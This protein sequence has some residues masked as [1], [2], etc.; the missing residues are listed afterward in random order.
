MTF[1]WLI[2]LSFETNC[3]HLFNID[4][5]HLLYEVINVDMLTA[6]QISMNAPLINQLINCFVF[7][8]GC[9]AVFGADGDGVLGHG[10]QRVATS[11][12]HRPAF[13][14]RGQGRH[15]D[16]RRG[17][18]QGHGRRG[19]HLASAPWPRFLAPTRKVPTG[20]VKPSRHS[21]Q[22]K[23]DGWFFLGS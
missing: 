22:E 19:A 21:V 15:W 11:V 14:A 7:L 4:V 6:R 10:D 17:H 1:N 5:P 12:P 23:N 2:F 9:R 13:G 3:I 20:E 8:A 18:P 16:Q